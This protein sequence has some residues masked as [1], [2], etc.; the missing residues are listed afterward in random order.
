MH[1]VTFQQK[2]AV[3]FSLTFP[4]GAQHVSGTERLTVSD[5]ACYVTEIPLSIDFVA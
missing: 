1:E 4:S 2:L 5:Q 3:A